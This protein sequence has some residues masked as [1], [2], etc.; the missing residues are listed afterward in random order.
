MKL[1]TS[2]G[3]NRIERQQYCLKTWEKHGTITAVQVPDDIAILQPL[4]PTVD[5]V[6]TELTGAV[7]YGLANRPRI[8]ALVDQGPGL[9]LNSDIK[10]TSTPEDFAK[11]WED[12]DQEFRVGIRYDFDGPGC[13]KKLNMYG[14][15]A[16]LLTQQVVEQL[17]D[18][19][20]VIGVSVWDYWIVWHMMTRR[21]R[22]SA[23]TTPGLLHLRHPQNWGERDTELGLSI[24]QSVYGL[25]EPK[26]IL[27]SVIPLLTG[28]VPRLPRGRLKWTGP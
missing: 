6:E 11:D 12:R 26:R 19:G 10:I 25:N 9:L 7:N 22:I 5:F 21:F 28:R 14:I 24:M 18:L 8:K 4:F 2:L 15:D 16:F 13:A 17:P 20:F 1:I 3:L 27:D 23:K